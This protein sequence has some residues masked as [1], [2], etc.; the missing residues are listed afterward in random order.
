MK[1]IKSR[2]RYN[3]LDFVQ[4]LGKEFNVGCRTGTGRRSLGRFSSIPEPS[5]FLE[6]KCSVVSGKSLLNIKV[7]S[8]IGSFNKPILNTIL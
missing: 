8:V 1:V 7:D 3:V 6:L 4:R 2:E 5:M